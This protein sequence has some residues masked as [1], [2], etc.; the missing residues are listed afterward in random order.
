MANQRDNT[1]IF[2]TFFIVFLILAM[3]IYG[4]IYRD[5]I[6]EYIQKITKKTENVERHTVKTSSDKGPNADREREIVRLDNR[7]KFIPEKTSPIDLG[8]R[9]NVPVL[10]SDREEKSRKEEK[11]LGKEKKSK[12]PPLSEP[13]YDYFDKK[14][15]PSEKGNLE[16]QENLPGNEKPYIASNLKSEKYK[17][18]GKKRK[19]SKKA[20]FKKRA[21]LERR[22][23]RLE[24]KLKV[25]S[26]KNKKKNLE[27]RV[28]RLEKI[29]NKK[30]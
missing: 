1:S 22:V 6:G 25:F 13:E 21:S 14:D 2:L 9:E 18:K 16:F 8:M 27:K 10:P 4:F 17:A 29:V 28:L 5:K 7:E 23:A 24:K 12:T 26:T 11:T 19:T 20:K 30:K 3:G 15:I